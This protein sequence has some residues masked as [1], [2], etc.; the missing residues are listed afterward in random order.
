[1]C[2]IC[3]QRHGNI[4]LCDPPERGALTGP[5]AA[6]SLILLVCLFCGLA[7][8]CSG[9][10]VITP[11]NLTLHATSTFQLHPQS[12]G[13]EFLFVRG[14]GWVIERNDVA[15]KNG[16]VVGFHSGDWDGTASCLRLGDVVAWD[17]YAGRNTL[18][19]DWKPGVTGFLGL[20]TDPTDGAGVYYAGWLFA[21]WNP[22]SSLTLLNCSYE[23]EA[24]KPLVIVPEPAPVFIF[25]ALAA[26]LL[27]RRNR[28]DHTHHEN[29][30]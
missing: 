20:L 14:D 16:K 10:V 6:L 8:R 26:L 3:G 13:P 29:A 21:R 22:D 2:P 9:A 4:E 23:T 7:G 5:F 12:A 1:M 24:G 11:L 18:R 25:F 15:N 28:T 17:N 19:W 27:L 30:P